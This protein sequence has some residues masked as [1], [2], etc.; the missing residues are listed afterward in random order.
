MWVKKLLIYIILFGVTCFAIL[1]N[2]EIEGERV[3]TE[4][5]NKKIMEYKS[6]RGIETVDL[7]DPA[8]Q[9][10]LKEGFDLNKEVSISAV[11][12]NSILLS[13]LFLLISLIYTKSRPIEVLFFS[14]P[15]VIAILFLPGVY[16]LWLPFISWLVGTGISRYVWH[17][18]NVSDN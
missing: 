12:R 15:F 7:N 9:A 11:K 4:Y 6:A 14:P 3:A 13:V 10:I 2:P 1:L 18:K 8:Y 17:N 16:V 5:S